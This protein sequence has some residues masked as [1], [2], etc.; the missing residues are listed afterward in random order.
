MEVNFATT[1]IPTILLWVLGL[2]VFLIGGLLGYFNVSIDA[3]KKM[4]IADQKIETAR[5]EADRRISEA[6]KMLDEARAL[7]PQ[8]P[9]VVNEPSLL[10]L[11][12][13]DNLRIQVEMDGQALNTPLNAERKARLIELVNHLRPWLEA[14]T[15]QPAASAPRTAP[16]PRP[17]PAAVPIVP[18]TVKPVPANLTLNPQKPKTNPE[19]EFKL[20]SIVRQIDVVLQR[21]IV[22]T[23]LEKMGV[24]L[25]DTLQGGLEVHIGTNIFETIDDVPDANIKA[26]IRAAISEWEQKYVP[27]TS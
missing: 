17:E 1:T 16:L 11:K 6:Q 14:P 21:R 5:G 7:G 25:Q 3:R 26:A 24:H 13:T 18:P 15:S 23:P 22:D 12:N 10:R 27:G 2:V 9:Q 8:A 19:D 20:L 4:D